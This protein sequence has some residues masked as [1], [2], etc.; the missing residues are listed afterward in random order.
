LNVEIAVKIQ[1]LKAHPIE[2]R[3]D[4][5]LKLPVDGLL[6]RKASRLWIAP[7]DAPSGGFVGGHFNR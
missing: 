6:L 7:D 5:V 2:K 3:P 1:F 4:I